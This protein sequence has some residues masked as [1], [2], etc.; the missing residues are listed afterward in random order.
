[1][2]GGSD[3]RPRHLEFDKTRDIIYTITFITGFMFDN[4][5]QAIKLRKFGLSYNVISKKLKVAKGTL[6]YWFKDLAVSDQIKKDNISKAKRKW[7]DNLIA[8]NKGRSLKARQNWEDTQKVAEKQV[9]SVSDRE[10]FLIGVALYW[11]EGYKKGNWNVIFCNAD[12]GTNC[13]M[14]E[15][16]RKICK[17]PEEKIKAQV[18]IHRNIEADGSIRYWSRLIKLPV[19]HFLK[20]MYQVSK[21]SKFR[22]G[23]TLPYGTLRIKINDVLLVNKIKGWIRGLSKSA[24]YGSIG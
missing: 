21:A 7:A 6:S 5:K 23:N 11:A 19:S 9:K 24:G 4:K 17:V 2:R 13:V 14:M 22:R 1:M 15:F 16:F 3:P 10:L 20:P 8:Y 12:P 18:Q